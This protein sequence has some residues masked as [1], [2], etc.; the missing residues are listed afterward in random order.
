[1]NSIGPVLISPQQRVVGGC[2]RGGQETNDVVC[3]TFCMGINVSLCHFPSIYTTAHPANDT[4]EM[5]ELRTCACEQQNHY[6]DV[7]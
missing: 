6:K 5:E 4:S 3:L 1:M 7:L 2:A